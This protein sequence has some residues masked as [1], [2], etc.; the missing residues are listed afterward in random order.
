[1]RKGRDIDNCI[2]PLLGCERAHC[3]PRCRTGLRIPKARAIPWPS[4]RIHKSPCQVPSGLVHNSLRW[5]RIRP[6]AAN[7]RD[8][9]FLR[10]DSLRMS[11]GVR[12]F[13]ITSVGCYRVSARRV[14]ALPHQPIK[15]I[16][17][18]PRAKEQRLPAIRPQ[19]KPALKPGP[20]IQRKMSVRLTQIVRCSSSA[21]RPY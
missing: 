19:H 16:G 20:S 11:L 3:Q 6:A 9:S 13:C 12:P 15:A 18:P 21:L 1:M 4:R 5:D 17:R 2:T 8:G 10:P 7:R 14:G